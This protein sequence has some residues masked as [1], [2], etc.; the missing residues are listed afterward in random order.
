MLPM[1]FG[2]MAL[3]TKRSVRTSTAKPNA[4]KAKDA[5]LRLLESYKA[6][7]YTEDARDLCDAMRKAYPNGRDVLKACGPAPSTPAT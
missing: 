5:Y 1:K 4:R 2:R 3:G 7:K 6:I